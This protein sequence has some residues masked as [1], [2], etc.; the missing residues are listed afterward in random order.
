MVKTYASL[1]QYDAPQ[2]KSGITL[3]A[4]FMDD[5]SGSGEALVNDIGNRMLKGTFTTIKPGATDWAK[6]KILDRATLN[7]LQILSDRP[8]VIATVTNTDTVLEC[9]FGETHPFGQKKGACRDNY[10]NRCHVNFLP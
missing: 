5:G 1:V 9:V 2:I 3:D 10:G 6:P 4:Q 7:K 8:W